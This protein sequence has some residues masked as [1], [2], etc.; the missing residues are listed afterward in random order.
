MKRMLA[1]ALCATLGGCVEAGTVLEISGAIRPTGTTSCLIVGQSDSSLSTGIYDPTFN[2]ALG[3]TLGLRMINHMEDE[4]YDTVTGPTGNPY[5]PPANTASVTGID[6]CFYREEDPALDLTALTGKGQVLVD[7]TSLPEEQ[8]LFITSSATIEP[9][10]EAPGEAVI[11]VLSDENLRVLYGDAFDPKNVPATGG[12]DN[13]DQAGQII[14]M[15]ISEDPTD[16]NRDAS[17]GNFPARRDDTVVIQAKAHAKLQTGW[18]VE[19]NEFHF[20]ISVQV[21]QLAEHCGYMTLMRCNGV[22]GTFCNTSLDF[23]T[24]D[25]QRDCWLTDGNNEDCSGLCDEDPAVACFPYAF[26]G[27]APSVVQS[28]C[29]VYQGVNQVGCEQ[30]FGCNAI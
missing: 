17:W 13:P 23:P 29:L 1:L 24:T 30:T 2:G 3:Y 19:S 4:S 20:P 26:S 8:Q 6:T 21:G 15:H 16:A 28:L 9:G 11:D 27:D 10:D 25:D 7:C 22:C 5:S 14:Y 18:L 12:I